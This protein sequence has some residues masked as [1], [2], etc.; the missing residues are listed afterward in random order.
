[1]L[2]DLPLSQEKAAN[3]QCL[4]GY[5]PVASNLPLAAIEIGFAGIEAESLTDS[6][7]DAGSF[8]LQVD[9]DRPLKRSL[10][11]AVVAPVRAPIKINPEANT[12]AEVTN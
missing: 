3:L 4:R 7:A 10:S 1:M 2:S 8:L 11:E 9:F 6:L 5:R 12:L